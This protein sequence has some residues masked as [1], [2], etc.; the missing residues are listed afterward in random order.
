[1]S[2]D[3]GFGYGGNYGSQSLDANGNLNTDNG[4]GGLTAADMG[5][6]DYAPLAGTSYTNADGSTAYIG[7]D[8]VTYT[9]TTAPD[10]STIY[11]A[12]NGT[13]QTNAGAT[14]PGVLGSLASWA[15]ANP[16]KAAQLGLT[17]AALLGAAQ[18]AQTN[19]VAQSAALQAQARAAAHQPVNVTRADGTTQTFDP[20]GSMSVVP[21]SKG[22]IPMQGD[23]NHAGETAQHVFYNQVNPLYSGASSVW[24]PS[25]TGANQA[26]TTQPTYTPPAATTPPVAPTQIQNIAQGTVA[27]GS[28]PWWQQNPLPSS[29]IA[30][31]NTTP[32]AAITPPAPSSQPLYPAQTPQPRGYAVGGLSHVGQVPGLGSGQADDVNAKLSSGEFVIP[33]DVVSHLGDGSTD[34][35]ANRLYQLM[36][37]VRT[38]KGSSPKNIPPPAKPV[39]QYLKGGKI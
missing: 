4:Y 34:A 7:A 37:S 25:V 31:A 35:G 3:Y 26:S 16:T 38:Q 19:P 27:A 12:P 23:P 18:S 9:V 36:H 1:M 21:Q 29:M 11:T 30:G 32:V 5:S 15:M 14:Q 17:G 20:Y 8:G 22:Y 13:V 39:A 33:A 6:M 10:G 28:T 24:D 2:T